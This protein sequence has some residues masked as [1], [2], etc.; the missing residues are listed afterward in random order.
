MTQSPVN[1][2]VKACHILLNDSEHRV[3]CMKNTTLIN[4][5]C[6]FSFKSV[7]VMNRK[8]APPVKAVLFTPKHREVLPESWPP[9]SGRRRSREPTDHRGY[10]SLLFEGLPGSS[11]EGGKKC[12]CWSYKWSVSFPKASVLLGGCGCPVRVL[13]KPFWLW[14][15]WP[16]TLADLCLL[17]GVGIFSSSESLGLPSLPQKVSSFPD[18]SWIPKSNLS[19]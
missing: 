17:Q 19:P 2:W 1:I 11:H 15:P 4:D 5:L 14:E 10:Y 16:F 6:F 9:A 8:G 7:T 12:K 13:I 18:F 3:F